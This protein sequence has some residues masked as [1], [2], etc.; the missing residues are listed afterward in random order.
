M[1]IQAA[2]AAPAKS[3]TVLGF[4]AENPQNAERANLLNLQKWKS[5][6]GTPKIG[7]NEGKW[8][9]DCG[10]DCRLSLGHAESRA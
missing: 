5:G 6:F 7:E 1:R 3:Q 2:G 9:K 10:G 4:G 8:R